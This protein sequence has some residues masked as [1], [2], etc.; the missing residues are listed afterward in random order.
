MD[1]HPYDTVC[2]DTTRHD[3]SSTITIVVRILD[4]KNVVVI[5]VSCYCLLIIFKL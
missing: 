1:L 5:D 2:H 3:T 4:E